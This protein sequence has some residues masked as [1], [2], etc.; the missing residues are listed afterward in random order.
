MV[1]VLKPIGRMILVSLLTLSLQV[2]CTEYE[3]PEFPHIDYY[4]VIT[5]SIGVEAGDSNY[6]FHLPVDVVFSPGGNIAVLDK[7]KHAAFVFTSEGEF[8]RSVGREGDGPGEFRMPSSIEFSSNGNFLIQDKKIAI[9]DSTFNYVDQMTWPRYPP[10]LIKALDEGGFVGLLGN[11]LPGEYGVVSVQT[12]ARWDEGDSASVEY[13]TISNEFDPDDGTIDRSESREDRLYCCATGCG[14]V[15]YSQ[16]SV[17]EYVII[18][19][20]SDG[21]EFLRIENPDFHRIRK[22]DQEMQA[23]IDWFDSFMAY[24]GSTR[25][26]SVQPDPFRR[27]VL[28]MF[29]IGE[30]ELWVR[31]GSFEGI[32]FRVYDM[33]GEILF[34]VKLE[35]PGDPADLINWEVTGSEHGFLAYETMPEYYPR[36]YVLTPQRSD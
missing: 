32:V 21:T 11:F 24:A 16:S 19:C 25:D 17:D 22:T 14:R 2:G 34:H 33:T 12:L 8:I 26:L 15:F 23:E 31:L 7:L 10:H 5:D 20:E 1:S 9:F 35:Y 30:D 36:I 18:G 29:T 27:V 28:G 6:M 3:E 13:A 4:L